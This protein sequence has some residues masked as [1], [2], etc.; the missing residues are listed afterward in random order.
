MSN[1]QH[2]EV[3]IEAIYRATVE[4]HRPEIEAKLE[5]ARKALSEACDIADQHG[6]PFYSKLSEIGQNYGPKKAPPDI[7][8][9]LMYELTGVWA[10]SFSGYGWEHSAVC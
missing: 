4:K 1:E 8:G 7:S 5:A 6:I 10:D 3:N 9:D 2:K